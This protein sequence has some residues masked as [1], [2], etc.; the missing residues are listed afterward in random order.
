MERRNITG[1]I[2]E[3]LNERDGN[4]PINVNDH[5]QV[6]ISSTYDNNVH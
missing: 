6:F 2:Y 1:I 4:K 5:V 3:C